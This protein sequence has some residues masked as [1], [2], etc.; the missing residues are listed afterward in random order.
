MDAFAEA[1]ATIDAEYRLP[2]EH[3]NPM[4][5]FGTTV[6]WDDGRL[7]VYDKTQ[8]VQNV[9]GYVCSMLGCARDRVRVLAPFVGGAFGLGLRPQYQVFLAALAAQILKRSVRVSC[10]VNKCS[11]WAIAP[12]RGSA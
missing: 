9:Q 4:E 11:A 12:S 8:G 10:R 3:H 6:M 5:L 7:T 2:V 1:Y